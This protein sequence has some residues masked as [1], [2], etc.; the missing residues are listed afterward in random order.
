MD[1]EETK[2][3]LQQILVDIEQCKDWGGYDTTDSADFNAGLVSAMN[4]V[5]R[6]L[7]NMFP[8]VNDIKKEMG[9]YYQ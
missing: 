5:Q 8:N 6:R 3:L 4:I 2:K 1:N 9:L 7:N